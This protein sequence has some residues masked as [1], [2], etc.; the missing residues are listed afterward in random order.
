[1]A[2]ESEWSKEMDSA[3][4]PA[5]GELL[6]GQV[7]DIGADG[8]PRVAWDEVTQNQPRVALSTQPV[9]GADRGRRVA[10]AFAANGGGE[11]V[12]LGFI[13]S[14]LDQV[15]S[16][17]LDDDQTRVVESPAA[18]VIQYTEKGVEIHAQQSLTL[19]CGKSRLTLTEDGRVLVRAENIV[20]RARASHQIKGGSV[21]LN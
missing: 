19:V 3:L 10:L 14:P 13:H 11:P 12:I 15:L 8:R 18:P 17:T 20:S 1:M 21:H 7:V 6:L 2:V 9:S 16:L 4:A 5:P